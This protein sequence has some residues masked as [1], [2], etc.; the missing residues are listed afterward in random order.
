[1]PDGRHSDGANPL[2]EGDHWSAT[3]GGMEPTALTVTDDGVDAVDDESMEPAF[4]K[5]FRWALSGVSIR[6]MPGQFAAVV[7]PPGSGKTTLTYLIPRFHDA[8]RGVTLIDGIDVRDITLSSLADVV[9]VVTQE[10]YVFHGTIRDNLA[11]AR[12]DATQAE[13]EQ[14]ARDANIHDRVTTLKHGY[15]TVVGDRGYH[16]SGAEKQLLAIGRVLLRNPRVLVLDEAT[17]ELDAKTERL[18]QEALRR[19]TRDRTTIAIAHRLSTILEADVIFGLDNGR[20]VERGTHA[21]LLA[22]GGLYW[23]LYTEQF[24][25]GQVEARL[26]DGVKFTDGSVMA[27]GRGHHM[28]T[29]VQC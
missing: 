5:A 2:L 28:R 1:V 14:A 19:A 26:Y 6:V 12:P 23:R 10:P 4:P 16:L 17:S 15:D 11:Y 29:D 13:I 3:V 8:D 22:H 7:G 24:A 27:G 9:G 25:A 20:I 21:E 18:V